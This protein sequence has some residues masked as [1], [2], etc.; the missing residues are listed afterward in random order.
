MVDTHVDGRSKM[1][2]W[3][4]VPDGAMAGPRETTDRGTDNTGCQ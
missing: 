1:Q 2:K 3:K 4:S